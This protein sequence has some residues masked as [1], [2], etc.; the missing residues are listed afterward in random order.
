MQLPGFVDRGLSSVRS[1]RKGG[2]V[3]SGLRP[4]P[5]LSG[6]LPVVGHTVEFVRA[7][8]EMLFRANREL[9]EVAAF[10]VFHRDM[11][12]M[13]GPEAHEAVFRAPDALLSPTEAYT[14]AVTR[15]ASSARRARSR[16]RRLPARTGR[17][18]CRCS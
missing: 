7:T 11:V 8:L 15:A 12:A 9:G 2:E 4:A 13:F 16:T 1:A 10:S 3:P 5:R 6:G 17:D 14:A 18:T